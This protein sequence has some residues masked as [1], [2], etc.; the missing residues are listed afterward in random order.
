M[1]KMICCLS[2]LLLGGCLSMDKVPITHVYVI[3]TDHRVCSKRRVTDKKTLASA[4]VADLPLDA[5]DGNVS[6]TAKEFLD[7][8]TYL[9]Q[10]GR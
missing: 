4:W 5:C 9:K 6:V 7:T 10:E 8:R 1:R 3:D 2:I